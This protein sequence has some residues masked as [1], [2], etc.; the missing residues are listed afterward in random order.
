MISEQKLIALLDRNI[1]LYVA[2]EGDRLPVATTPE[3]EVRNK[4]AWFALTSLKYDIEN[5]LHDLEAE[6]TKKYIG[7]L[8]LLD[9]FAVLERSYHDLSE[10]KDEGKP[11][12]NWQNE[13]AAQTVRKIS[14]DIQ[15][16]IRSGEIETL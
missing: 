5:K 14:E 13:I 15:A 2:E 1:A 12:K 10:T 6:S 9:G 3:D 16:G 7:V 11:I 4:G 8:D